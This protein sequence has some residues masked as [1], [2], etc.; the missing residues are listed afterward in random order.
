VTVTGAGRRDAGA[1]LTRRL[2]AILL[3]V[4]AGVS[5]AFALVARQVY[6]SAREQQLADARLH[7]V[8]RIESMEQGWR[9]AAF[10][11]AQQLELWQAG[12]G[13]MPADAREARLRA[14]VVTLVDQGDFTH[15]L[16]TADDGELLFSHGTRSQGVPPLPGA[17]DAQGR[18]WVYSDADRTMYRTLDGPLRFGDRPARLL[19]YFPI[20]NALLGRLVYPSTRLALSRDTVTLAASDV[21]APASGAADSATSQQASLSLAWDGLAGA[22]TLRID[23]RFA[24]PLSLPQLLL[25]VAGSAAAL[26][27]V[28]WLVLGRWL[29]AQ[30]QRLSTLQ[31]AA[32]AF[33]AEPSL[34]PAVEA[35]LERASAEPDDIGVLGV[36]LREMMQR[37][38]AASTEQARA[39]AALAA[40]NVRLEDRVAERTREL[41]KA[42]DDAL[43]AAVAKE[44]FLSNMSHEIRT[45]MN[46]MLGAMELLSG[47]SLTPRQAEYI[48]VAATS[49][50]A[51]M[52]ILN[53][54]LDYAKIGAGELQLAREP[55][56][57][58]AV[59]RSVSTLFSAS[60]QRKGLTLRLDADPALAGWRDG[61]ALR[62]RQ[63][64]MNLVGN[65]MK[66][67]Q[68]GTIVV[69]TRRRG[70]GADE[71]VLF[72]VADT[73]VGIDPS[74]HERI[75]EPFVQAEA[76]SRRR[77][78]GTGLGLAI[79]RQLVRAMGGELGL[80][81]ALG[82]GSVF[83]F[84]L[85]LPP[86]PAAQ[87]APP[88]ATPA[89]ADRRLQG[90][91]LLVEDNS[92]NQLVGSAML[93]SLGIT[94]LVAEHGEQALDLLA[95]TAVALVLMDCQ[96]P[97]MDGY[98][99]THRLRERERLNGG[100]RT[101]VIALT[102][103]ALSGDVERCLAAGMDAHLAKPYTL[104]QLHA[105]VAPWLQ[106]G[107]GAAA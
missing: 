59:A 99:A 20:D 92:V 27:V 69:R 39:Q 5:A 3:L 94:V 48:E 65:A 15:A 47:T 16:I 73:G 10:A 34:R 52:G 95:E 25:W 32:T 67:T 13:T 26:A 53:D 33:A 78:G 79:S 90:R 4:F 19:L 77:E 76:P 8:S 49:G 38:A 75:F 74:Q 98:E 64:L 85:A 100:S 81:S 87:A 72:E 103:N 7:F 91:V 51:L 107:D 83:R 31:E 42:R 43:A 46:G 68:R 9:N 35:A 57:V 86:A 22:P 45:P 93:E 82:R 63:V 101:P 12:A 36:K 14:F 50:E 84:E 44:R 29:R 70:E 40:L 96:M 88:A 58:N 6:D 105:T 104:Q 62:L 102:A 60:A 11:V 18:G 23:R 54:V 2:L 30:A 17:R 89:G 1:T 28:G 97:V 66:F 37:I 55:I 61:D 21:G 56:D 24:A 41:E 71:R 80:D 106:R